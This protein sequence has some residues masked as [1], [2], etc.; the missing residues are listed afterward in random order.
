[1]AA[2]PAK[3]ISRAGTA[4]FDIEHISLE[5]VARVEAEHEEGESEGVATFDRFTVS[6]GFRLCGRRVAQRPVHA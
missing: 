4:D 3:S 1:M 2:C 6:G 5:L